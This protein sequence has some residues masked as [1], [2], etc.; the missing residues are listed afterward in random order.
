MVNRES[1]NI[2]NGGHSA[3]ETHQNYM[4]TYKVKRDRNSDAKT[5][6]RKPQQNYRFGMDSNALLVGLI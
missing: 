3:N 2:P 6:N 1:S 4:N 5:G